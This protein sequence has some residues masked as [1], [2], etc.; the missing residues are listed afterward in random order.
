MP[1]GIGASVKLIRWTRRRARSVS[2]G[3]WSHIMKRAIARS[4]ASSRWQPERWIW[5]PR[6]NLAYRAD[7][8]DDDRAFLNGI[9]TKR[10]DKMRLPRKVLSPN[11]V[12]YARKSLSSERVRIIKPVP[13]SS[14][15]R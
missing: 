1:F 2:A 7:R 6:D 8:S 12:R 15:L 4:R 9:T 13:G 14:L 5:V 3:A 11:H 10:T